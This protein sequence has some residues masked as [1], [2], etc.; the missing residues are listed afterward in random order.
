MYEHF[1]QHK[2]SRCQAFAFQ[3]FDNRKHDTKMINISCKLDY[4]IQTILPLIP[5]DSSTDPDEVATRSL[6]LV[7]EPSINESFK[8]SFNNPSYYS[9]GILMTVC[10][11][12]V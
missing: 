6:L 2:P 7:R 12:V 5:T 1:R 8:T 11:Y 4:P 10:V 9:K 3:I